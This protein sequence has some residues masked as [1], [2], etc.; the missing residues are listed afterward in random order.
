MGVMRLRHTMRRTCV[1]GALLLCG[2]SNAQSQAADLVTVYV[3]AIENNA[4]YRSAVMQYNAAL[5][6]R[7]AARGKL[8]PQLGVQA[9]YD[10]IRQEVDGTY[11]GFPAIN[12]SDNFERYLYGAALSQT[13][14]RMDQFID[15]K[16]AD[17]QIGQARLALATAK[18]ELQVG[19]AKAY[20][21][22]LGAQ[23]TLISVRAEKE[24]VGRQ[25]DQMQGRFDS[26]MVADA[27]LKAAQSRQDLVLAQEISAENEVEIA[28][29]QIELVSGRLFADVETL[30]ADVPLPAL[31][32][33]RVENWI[34]RAMQHNLPLLEQTL[35]AHIAGLE[36]DKARSKRLPQ[37][38]LLGTYAFFDQDGSIS[39]AREDLDERIGVSVTLPIYSGGQIST[40]IRYADKLWKSEQA[41][42]ENARAQAL[43]STRSGFLNA[44]SALARSHAL[45]N[46]VQSA[47]AAEEAAQVGFDVGTRTQAE[48]LNAVRERYAAQRDFA[49]ARY[50]YL[51]STL[52]LKQAAGKLTAADLD[53]I[54]SM[55]R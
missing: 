26:G 38:D 5:E 45:E 30:P 15:L 48:L 23:E 49:L 32:Y 25:L 51:L 39:G 54:N 4:A 28:R 55:L 16:K 40:G 47:I 3:N 46:A 11:Y 10:W 37:I 7:P 44:R 20:F 13:I 27:D 34:D 14:F 17:S 31:E 29:T 41:L 18:D 19:V 8:L 50:A 6:A 9:D 22:L 36:Y 2:V 33:D 53:E 21:A 24:A 1:L 43:Q 12:S 35:V 52:E 42:L